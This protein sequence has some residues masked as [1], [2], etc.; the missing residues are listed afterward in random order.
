M[1]RHL[2][3]LRQA[4]YIGP[5][6]DDEPWI[7]P[8]AA[9]VVDNADP[10]RQGRL[11]L[12]VPDLG[13][14]DQHHV[15]AYPSAAP[16]GG[17]STDGKAWGSLFLPPNDAWVHVEFSDG[18]PDALVWLPGWFADGELPTLLE[19]GYPHRRGIVSPSG[20]FLIFDDRD[21]DTGNVGF[22]NREGG[23]VSFTAQ[24]GFVKAPPGKKLKLQQGQGAGLQPVVLKGHRV[25]CGA[26][27]VVKANVGL[28][29]VPVVID[30]IWTPPEAPVVPVVPG[31]TVTTTDLHGITDEG[32]AHLE[33]E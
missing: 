14:G 30:V 17:G 7:G 12:Q 33:S 27:H 32:S 28:G 22:G 1:Q 3:K 13:G 6:D 15:F 23:H 31:A 16:M 2:N 26:L 25:D 11:L 9:R 24:G 5:A 19:T 29:G 8:W 20:H 4:D 21:G 10:G 18:D